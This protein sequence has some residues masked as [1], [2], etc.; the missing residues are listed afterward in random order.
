MN[1]WV[2]RFIKVIKV[3]E[4]RVGGILDFL[5]KLKSLDIKWPKPNREDQ[6]DAALKADRDMQHQMLDIIQKFAEQP[7][8][9]G[10]QPNSMP[11]LPAITN[12]PLPAPF[13]MGNPLT[14]TQ[15]REISRW[16]RE[17]RMHHAG[18]L[19][20]AITAIAHPGRPGFMPSGL[21]LSLDALRAH[22]L[23][24]AD[25]HGILIVPSCVGYYGGAVGYFREVMRETAKIVAT[26]GAKP[27]S[28][29]PDGDL[30]RLLPPLIVATDLLES[31]ASLT[32]IEVDLLHGILAGIPTICVQVNAGP[33]TI[34]FWWWIPGASQIATAEH[35]VEL[36]QYIGGGQQA[37]LQ[38]A[39]TAQLLTLLLSDTLAL[40]TFEGADALPRAIRRSGAESHQAYQL[41]DQ[42]RAMYADM[43]RTFAPRYGPLG[44]AQGMPLSQTADEVSEV[45]PAFVR[46]LRLALLNR[47]YEYDKTSDG[48]IPR[49][50]ASVNGWTL[51]PVA[52]VNDEVVNEE[53]RHA[54]Y[55]LAA[56]PHHGDQQA[57][58]S[59]YRTASL[60]Y[61]LMGWGPGSN[62][63]QVA[64]EEGRHAFIH[65]PHFFLDLGIVDLSPTST[66]LRTHIETH[67]HSAAQRP[68]PSASTNDTYGTDAYQRPARRI[69]E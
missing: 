48:S 37:L 49:T 5:I 4:P 40:G 10:Y 6:L 16:E 38:L 13:A 54:V 17:L 60:K 34:Q 12:P 24:T 19:H 3:V 11:V 56:Q 28:A 9:S 52:D 36:G 41:F 2:E 45:N 32:P 66:M 20:A 30:T 26:G 1:E 63:W 67:L 15:L 43:Y 47:Q 59:C 29:I 8:V 64:L 53:Q 35:Q 65:T 57:R 39:D 69:E 22:A 42:L 27:F 21:F 51:L 46:Q 18:K 55:V 61:H 62:N 25:E 7:R 33:G 31:G 50:C 23:R 44:L 58:I 68:A 14:A